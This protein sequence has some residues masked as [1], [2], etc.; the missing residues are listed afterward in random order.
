[1]WVQSLG[2]EEELLLG[3]KSKM[4]TTSKLRD[5]ISLKYNLEGRTELLLGNNPR[6][7]HHEQTLSILGPS[8][9]HTTHREGR[10][11][12]IYLLR[13]A[14][15]VYYSHVHPYHTNYTQTTEAKQ[16]AYTK[17]CF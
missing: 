4:H 3:N 5:P 17:T 16:K 12:G 13:H 6:C 9:H 2:L 10:A 11:E 1:M 15:R 8:Q 14:I 7:T